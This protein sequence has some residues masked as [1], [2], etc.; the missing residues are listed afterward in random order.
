MDNGDLARL[1]TAPVVTPAQLHAELRARGSI[2]MF[3][4]HNKTQTPGNH[5]T[6]GNIVT[7]HNYPGPDPDVGMF[8]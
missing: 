3:H 6:G 4:R 2:F 8:E 7:S 1:I 5:K